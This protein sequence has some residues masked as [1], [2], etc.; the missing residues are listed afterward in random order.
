M[1]AKDTLA[2][3]FGSLTLFL[4]KPFK[5]GDTVKIDNIKGTIKE[6]GIRSTKIKAFNGT[7]FVIPNNSLSNQTIEN[8]SKRQGVRFDEVL[9]LIYETPNSK[10]EAAISI[11]KKI[12]TNHTMVK[13]DI[14]RVHLSQF[15]DFSLNLT[16]TYYIEVPKNR[17]QLIDAKNEIN[18]QIKEQFEKANI[19]FAYPTQL[20]LN[21]EV[22]Q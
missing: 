8:V 10:I 6:I 2:N 21:K 16:M 11:V 3:F 7:Y 9:G 14:I 12:L 1:A 20:L 17:D 22:K 15:A 5:I 13:K 19:E 4:D 18:L